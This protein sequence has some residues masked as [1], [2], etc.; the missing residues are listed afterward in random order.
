M[1]KVDRLLATLRG[2]APPEE[3][4]PGEA[5]APAVS[6]EEL[7]ALKSKLAELEDKLGALAAPPPLEPPPEL[8]PEEVPP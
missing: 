6:N 8:S 5:S 2:E 3:P 4:A 7:D 1:A